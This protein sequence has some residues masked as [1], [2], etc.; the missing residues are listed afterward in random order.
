MRFVRMCSPAFALQLCNDETRKTC[1]YAGPASTHLPLA[2]GIALRK[3]A[4]PH[5]DLRINACS[6]VGIAL[7]GALKLPQLTNEAGEKELRR[8]LTLE[9]ESQVELT[10]LSSI[11]DL[12]YPPPV[13]CNMYSSERF[14]QECP[15]RIGMLT[16]G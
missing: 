15:A 9:T 5:F 6:R 14:M 11:L 16:E 7:A 1:D 8:R 10:L 2:E 12:L 3:G 4:L 13:T